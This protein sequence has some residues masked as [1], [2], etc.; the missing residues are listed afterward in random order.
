MD[1]G[2]K[3]PAVGWESLLEGM[4]YCFGC[5]PQPEDVLRLIGDDPDDPLSVVVPT[6]QSVAEAND[7]TC[8]KCW[9]SLAPR[10]TVCPDVR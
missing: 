3:D 7:D 6:T 4:P 5:A 10:L 1:H 9:E 8:W 2:I